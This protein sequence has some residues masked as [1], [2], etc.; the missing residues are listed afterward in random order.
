MY[1]FYLAVSFWVIYTLG[2]YFN[3]ILLR[4][5][6]PWYQ[7]LTAA[8]GTASSTL[9]FYFLWVYIDYVDAMFNQAGS[10]IS[11]IVQILQSR[12]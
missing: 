6:V 7:W 1:F 3:L 12:S 2:G 11:M 10:A 9:L 8:S 4:K 5:Q